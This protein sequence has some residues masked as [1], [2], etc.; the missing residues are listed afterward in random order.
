MRCILLC[1]EGFFSGL[2]VSLTK[3]EL[4]PTWVITEKRVL[5]NILGCRVSSVAME[6]LRLSLGGSFQR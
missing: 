3:S 6:Y 5:T 2:R 4:V 1:I